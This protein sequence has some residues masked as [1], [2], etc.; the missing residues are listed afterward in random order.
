MTTDHFDNAAATWDDEPRRIALM[1]AIGEVILDN[2]QPSRATTVL[3]YG[4]G[5]GLIGLFLLPHVG[6]VTGADNSPGML[7]VLRRKIADNGIKNMTAIHLDLQTEPPLDQE[8]DLIL[9]GMAMHHIAEID[10]VLRGFHKM[11]RPGGTVCIADLDTEPGLFHTPE[12]AASVHHNGFDR[13]ALK[14]RMTDA[15]FQAANDRTVLTFKKPVAEQ[16]DHEF[17]VFLVSATKPE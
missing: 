6:Q 1:R 12:A 7:T 13:E 2:V 16:A 11:L 9:C 17:S 15:G 4:C 14:R 10:R 8:F 3:D 5:T